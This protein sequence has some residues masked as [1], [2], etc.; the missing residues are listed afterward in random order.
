MR[1][2][3]DTKS[4]GSLFD[5]KPKTTRF[6]DTKPVLGGINRQTEDDVVVHLFAGMS[7]GPGWYMYVT[8]P[9]EILVYP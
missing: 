2:L 9:T 1:R 8:Y 6:I 3:V 4:S 5:V 7:M